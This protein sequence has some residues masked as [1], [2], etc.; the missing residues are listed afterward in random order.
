MRA[1]TTGSTGLRQLRQRAGLTQN[2][3][4]RRLATHPST[5]SQWERGAAVPSLDAIT[6]LAEALGC[7]RETVLAAI[8]AGRS[9]KP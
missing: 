8:D 9:S 2:A 6:R 4:A 3:L 5:V 7:D 1:K